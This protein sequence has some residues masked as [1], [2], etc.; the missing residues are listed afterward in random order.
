MDECDNCET[1]AASRYTLV[2][3]TGLA[4][5]DRLLCGDCRAFFGRS[6][7]IEVFQG[8]VLMRGGEV[9]EV[10]EE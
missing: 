10:E 7:T 8:P 1:A 9:V 6:D 2:F 4:L 5:R 3:E